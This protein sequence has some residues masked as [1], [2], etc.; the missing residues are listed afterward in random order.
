MNHVTL[1]GNLTKDPESRVTTGSNQ[2]TVCNFTLAVNDR[3]K[4]PRSGDWVDDTCFIPV[5]VWGKQ[6]ENCDKYLSKGSK[7]LVEGRIK[8]SSYEKDGRKIYRTDVVATNVEFLSQKE[9]KQDD[10]PAGFESIES[11]P[12]PF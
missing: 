12:L 11:E 6:G 10:I 5:V 9:Q 2:T 4:D 8:T 1:T 3:R 7:C